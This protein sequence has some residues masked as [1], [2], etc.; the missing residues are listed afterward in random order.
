MNLSDND[1]SLEVMLA[2]S[3]F[4]LNKISDQN[5]SENIQ[6]SAHSEMYSALNLYYSHVSHL[7]GGILALDAGLIALQQLSV[8]TSL[9]LNFLF[10]CVPI[11]IAILAGVSIQIL[12]RYYE[13]YV[14]A[15]VYATAMH[16]QH[17]SRHWWFLRTYIQAFTWKRERKINDLKSYVKARARSKQDTFHLYKIAV[18]C[19]IVA[20]GLFAGLLAYSHFQEFLSKC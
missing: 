9:L 5:F 8:N 6:T 17:L 16:R 19:L 10:I 7:I 14:A 3:E 13:V 2:D 4:W 15:L 20:N 18:W 12:M 1:I 11:V